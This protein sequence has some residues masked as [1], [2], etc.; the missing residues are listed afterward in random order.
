MQM[1][2]A[3]K[4]GLHFNVK[5]THCIMFHDKQC[6]DTKIELTLNVD[7]LGWSHISLTRVIISIAVIASENILIYIFI[8]P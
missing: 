3:N 5:K 4:N 6:A 7:I 1:L 2:F 8:V